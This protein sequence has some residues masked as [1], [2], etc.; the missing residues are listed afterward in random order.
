MKKNPTILANK[1]NPNAEQ[2]Q[3]TLE[4]AAHITELTQNPAIADALAALCGRVT[5]ELPCGELSDRDLALEFCRLMKE[6]GDVGARISDANR[7]D[8]DWGERLSPREMKAVNAELR[9]LLSVLVCMVQR[10]EV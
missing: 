6:C 5:V 9:E 7:P 8:S 1:L 2:N 3:L 10:T 4:E